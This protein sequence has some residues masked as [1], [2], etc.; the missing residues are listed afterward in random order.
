MG[1]Y[2]IAIVG[3]G[4]AGVATASLLKESG[5]DVT[6]FEQAPGLR[7]TGAGI[8]IEPDLP[9]LSHFG[10]SEEIREKGTP[11]DGI[12]TKKPG[13]KITGEIF[14]G[15]DTSRL[16][17]GIHREALFSVLVDKAHE[18][19][20]PFVTDCSI[21]SAAL[22]DG[23]RLLRDSAGAACGEFDLVIDAS[24]YKSELRQYGEV[25]RNKPYSYGLLCGVC[26]DHNDTHSMEL[27]SKGRQV[28]TVYPIGKTP[29]S[30]KN[31]IAFFWV[32]RCDQLQAWREA[33]L[34]AWKEKVLAHS[35]EMKPYVDQ[36]TS[37]DQLFFARYSSVIMRPE[38]AERLAFVG[39]AARSTSPVGGG[40]ANRG[41]TDAFALAQYLN[42]DL[43]LPQA[44]EAYSSAREHPVGI[45]RIANRAITPIFQSRSR[46]VGL[47]RDYG[48]PLGIKALA[49]C[50]PAIRMSRVVRARIA[51]IGIR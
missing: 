36:F 25:I 30:N 12:Q 13:G 47:L 32:M 18:L 21:Q 15:D 50:Q 19:N 6:V 51:S 3:G 40:G 27:H 8:V 42:S 4:L 45:Q 24:G 44:L 31:H 17:V 20:V 23:K 9:V 39:D 48:V 41:L 1:T 26:E 11:I 28:F 33:G 38:H 49:V 16:P 2:K 37:P 35:P 46:A 22:K 7:Y 10:L 43:D 29:G 34:D 14:Y 5:H